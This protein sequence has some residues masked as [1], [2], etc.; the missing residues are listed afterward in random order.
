MILDKVVQ[1]YC[2]TEGEGYG[3]RGTAEHGTKLR[4]LSQ[5]RNAE[6]SERIDGR[7]DR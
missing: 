2:I 5:N 3:D 4:R 1:T 7:K 6:T